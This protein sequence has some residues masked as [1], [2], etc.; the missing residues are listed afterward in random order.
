MEPEQQHDANESVGEELARLAR[1]A[2]AAQAESGGAAER[3]TRCQRVLDLEAQGRLESGRDYFY[4]GWIMI[5]GETREDFGHAHRLA[6]DRH[7]GASPAP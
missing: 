4:A 2:L 7:A 6:D 5:C 1:A 3:R